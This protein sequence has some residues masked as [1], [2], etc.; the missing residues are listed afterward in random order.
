M[1]SYPVL[2]LGLLAWLAP[3]DAARAGPCDDLQAKV[4]ADAKDGEGC[5]RFV[6]D[7]LRGSTGEQLSGLPRLMAC[8]MVLDDR[9]TLD[10]LG[11]RVKAAEDPAADVVG[12]WGIDLERTM[13]ADAKM[14]D[15]PE[16][17]KRQAMT[18]ARAFL[19]NMSFEFTADG[20]AIAKMGDKA[21]RS[22]FRVTRREGDTLTIEMV[23]G[24]GAQAKKET[25]TFIVD[26]DRLTMKQGSQ[27]LVLKR[28]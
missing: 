9:S 26:G 22:T 8:R 1:Q 17:A 13:H 4:C 28:R 12:V 21:E 14:R 6:G 10:D 3:I 19:G 7:Q 23:E 24:A 5:A 25:L 18:Q 11:Q 15:M 16:D 2:I 20:H 27:T